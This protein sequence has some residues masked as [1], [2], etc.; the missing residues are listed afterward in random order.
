MVRI[1]EVKRA[2]EAQLL[3]IPGVV[4]V[5]ISDG[6]LGQPVIAVY[7]ADLAS[8]KAVPKT[9]GGFPV[10]VRVSGEFD[11]LGTP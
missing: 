4:G 9:V 5:G 1:E 3:A 2:H 6:D 11:A 10:Q 7:V 8:G